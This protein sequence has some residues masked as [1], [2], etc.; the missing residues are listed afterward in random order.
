MFGGF[1]MEDEDVDEER[2]E[3]SCGDSGCRVVEEEAESSVS[4]VLP[5]ESEGARMR[6]AAADRCL[7]RMIC[8][9]RDSEKGRGGVGSGVE[10]STTVFRIAVVI[11]S[12]EV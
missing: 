4:E 8:A 5:E 2:V 9:I 10:Y 1:A 11:S 6:T 12:C 3:S 7:V